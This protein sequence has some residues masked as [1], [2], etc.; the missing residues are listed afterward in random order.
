MSVFLLILKIIGILLL[1][2]LGIVLLAVLLILFCPVT[3]RIRGSFHDKVPKLRARGFWLA[4]LLG[5]CVD[6]EEDT[7]IYLRIFGIKKSFS[8]GDNTWDF[9]DNIKQDRKEAA[10]KKIPKTDDPA[11]EKIHED[12][13]SEAISG[14]KDAPSAETVETGKI[15]FFQKIML[16]FQRIRMF[17]LR[18]IDMLKH[19]QENIRR[20]TTLLADETNRA[21]F[22]VI[23]EKLFLLLKILM[24]RKLKLNL[25]YSTGSPDTTGQLLGI[26]AMFPVGYQNRW[27]ITPDFT[28]EEV[29]AEADFDIRGHV[30]GIQI[31]RLALGIILDKNCQ[32]LY[33]KIDR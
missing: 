29:F 2:L 14:E 9:E 24:P 16:F 18:V 25:S 6:I 19:L 5:I 3:Y 28:S 7:R 20:V 23:G 30:F 27:N 8:E 31:F 13:F 22:K 17:F 4:G 10:K 1:I 12:A 21:A 11:A 33:N 15:S 32:K 26:L